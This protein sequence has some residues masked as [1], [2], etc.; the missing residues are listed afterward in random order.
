MKVLGLD[1]GGT[2]L[3]A[4]RVTNDGLSNVV[5]VMLPP[6]GSQEEI[7]N[8]IY[9]VIDSIFAAGLDGI[10]V[11]VPSV[12]DVDRGIVYDVVNI[13]SWKEVPLKLKLEQRYH[14]PAYVNNDA[15]CFAVG[16]K[17]FGAGKPYRDLVGLI[18]GTGLG[19][20]LIL[21][22]K[23]YPGRNCGAGEFG[24]IPWNDGV[25][26]NYCSGQFF[27]KVSKQSGESLFR[28]AVNG[29]R[30]A[31][32]IFEEFGRNLG[33]AIEIILLSVDPE[34]IVLG[35]SVSKAYELFRDAMWESLASFPYSRTV[36]RLHVDVS[37]VE[38]IAI[39]GAAA[40]LYDAFG[41]N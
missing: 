34:I 24:I 37:H 2:N 38:N 15:N 27:K 1:L 11:G 26:E 20:G 5:S 8:R 17:Y 35:G 40:L 22:N 23:L 33:R 7:L 28:E 3:R 39:L 18:I 21:N 16:E 13:P 19:A 29:D 32:R 10:G 6:N 41:W 4:G 25:L 9:D 30:Q 31:R 12:V 36:Q 14:I